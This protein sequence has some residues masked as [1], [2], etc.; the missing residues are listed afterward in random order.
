MK[1]D[2]NTQKKKIEAVLFDMDG[3]IFDTESVWKDAFF[4]ANKKFGLNLDE[5][6]RQKEMAGR[7]EI[8]IR[9]MMKL[10]FPDVDIDAYRDYMRG[11]V[12][13]EIKSSKKLL[14]TGFV[15]IVDALKMNNIKIALATSSG[16]D[17]CDILF[18][19]AGIDYKKIFDAIVTK[20]EV[21]SGKPNP[22]VF[23]KA[24]KKL[25]VETEACV[26]LEDSILGIQAA[27][28]AGA[29][30]VMVVDLIEP[31]DELRKL[32]EHVVYSLLEAKNFIL[33]IRN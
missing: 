23:L 29:V 11:L 26:V 18:G 25:G 6:Y 14:K 19:N 8:D 32:A 2:K 28:N 4:E 21:D 16:L 20:E 27:H 1:N 33:R 10:E 30:P 15:E 22:E 9:K 7:Q 3:L 13:E 24:A 12:F 31:V 17:R 5:E